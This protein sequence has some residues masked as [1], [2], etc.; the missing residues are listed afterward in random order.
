MSNK[1]I[2]L[3]AVLVVVGWTTLAAGVI[4]VFQG[5]PTVSVQSHHH[6]KPPQPKAPEGPMLSEDCG[7]DG[8]E[9]HCDQVG[10]DGSVPCSA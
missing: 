8:S 4:A 3:F 7:G 9:C 5:E 2:V 1:T 6:V 10:L